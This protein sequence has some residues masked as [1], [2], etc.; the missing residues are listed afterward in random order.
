MLV[1]WIVGSVLA[2]GLLGFW[3]ASL[4]G[5]AN[6]AASGSEARARLGVLEQSLQ[7]EKERR[8]ETEGRLAEVESRRESLD[9][10][11]VRA[12]ERADQATRLIEEQKSFLETSRKELENAFQA[13]AA[14]ALEGNSTQFLKVAEQRLATTREQAKHDL[15]TRQKGFETLLA[16]FRDTLTRLESRTGEIEKAREGAYKGLTEHLNWLKDATSNLKDETTGLTHALRGSQAR[17]R[18]G[19]I[20]L[21]NVVELAG[22]TE[23]CDFIEQGTTSDGGRPDLTVKLPGDRVIA[24]D[25]KVPMSAYLEAADTSDEKIRSE[26]LSSHVRAVRA[27]VKT[28]ANRDY[29]AALGTDVD[30]VVMF[31]PADP[32]LTV[33]FGEAPELQV[34]ALR[35]KVLLATPTTLVA[36]LRTVAIYW[37]QRDITENAEHIAKTAR[38]LYDRAA[39]FGEHLDKAGKGLATAVGAYNAA[40]GSFRS[41]VLPMGQKLLD[42]KAVDLPKKKLE[43]PREIETSPQDVPDQPSLDLT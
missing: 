36:L 43:S 14:R 17:G 37:Q 9:R 15:E 4:R 41:R 25:A 19:E 11:V 28:L 7:G 2:G 5:K 1:I 22:M 13:L 21:R 12:Q 38:E 16:P 34:E 40:V 8:L 20:A 35:A 31:L 23:H 39:I 3:I 26:A 6:L 10:E 29:A 18:W 42:L 33:A 24:V 30:L 32:L 27:H